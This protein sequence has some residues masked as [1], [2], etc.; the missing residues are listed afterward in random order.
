MHIQSDI[1]KVIILLVFLIIGCKSNETKV[2]KTYS[3]TEMYKVWDE[4]NSPK[5]TNCHTGKVESFLIMNEYSCSFKID[6]NEY[7]IIEKFVF[8]NGELK[9]YWNYKSEGAD[10]LSRTELLSDQ[11]YW[12][13]I[14]GDSLKYVYSN[15]EKS[16]LLN[17]E[18]LIKIEKIDF[19]NGL[20]FLERTEADKNKGFRTLLKIEIEE[21]M[22]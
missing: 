11:K 8:E 16:V 9:E 7:D 20:I 19:E 13:L 1:S 15:V 4:G 17:D 5:R 3:V 6:E 2:I 21:K 10:I 14:N 12:N 22:E 18:K